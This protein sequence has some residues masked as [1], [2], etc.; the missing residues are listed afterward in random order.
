[1]TTGLAHETELR[2]KIVSFDVVESL[3]DATVTLFGR[4][5]WMLKSKAGQTTTTI[6][7]EQRAITIH[8]PRCETG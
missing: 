2:W 8:I 1:M 3:C 6:A 7:M 4:L 5:D